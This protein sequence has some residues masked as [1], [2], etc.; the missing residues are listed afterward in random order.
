[1]WSQP[2]PQRSLT[3]SKP[4]D[5]EIENG[6]FDKIPVR[7]SGGRRAWLFI[8]DPFLQAD[9]QRLKAQI[10]LILAQDDEL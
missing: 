5:T 7:L 6:Q 9:K 8:P 4:I 3:Q 1:M 2:T 10:D